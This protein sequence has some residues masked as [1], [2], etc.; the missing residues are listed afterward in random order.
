[1]DVALLVTIHYNPVKRVSS[2]S[3]PFTFETNAYEEGKIISASRLTNQKG[4][5]SRRM[6]IVLRADE[7]ADKLLYLTDHGPVKVEVIWVASSDGQTWVKLPI[8]HNGVLSGMEVAESQATITIETLKGTINENR[9]IMMSDT[10][11]RA[12]YTDP[13]PDRGFEYVERF[14]NEGI[15]EFPPQ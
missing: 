11:Q 8:Q 9:T 4:L 6:S 14:R 3:T 7:D 13:T 5:P 2:F 1:M 15:L 10:M 12:L